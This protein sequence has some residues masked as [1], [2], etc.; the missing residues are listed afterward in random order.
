MNGGDRFL[1]VR[2]WYRSSTGASVTLTATLCRNPPLGSSLIITDADIPLYSFTSPTTST[3]WTTTSTTWAA[4]AAAALS[5]RVLD[6]DGIDMETRGM[7]Q[8]HVRKYVP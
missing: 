1:Q 6:A 3:T 8:M 5:L 7:C 4:G 2:P